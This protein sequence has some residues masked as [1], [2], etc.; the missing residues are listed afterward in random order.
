MT[1]FRKI[2]P[3]FASKQVAQYLLGFDELV[4]TVE[5]VFNKTL[6]NTPNFPPKN[7]LRLNENEYEL[8]YAVAGFSKEDLRISVE[9]DNLL[10]VEGNKVDRNERDPSVYLH[11]GIA[12]RDFRHEMTIPDQSEIKVELINGLLIIHVTK[13]V[14][15][16]PEP[17]LIAIQ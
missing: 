8:Q 4:N 17:K 10:V 3:S 7:I 2:D 9:R 12:L 13:P 14:K 11:R 16:E 15:L 6:D 1:Q 5:K